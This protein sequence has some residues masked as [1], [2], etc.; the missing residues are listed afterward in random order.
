MQKACLVASHLKM[1]PA[2]NEFG[3]FSC[4]S[5]CSSPERP[6]IAE[7]G[8]SGKLRLSVSVQTL[9]AGNGLDGGRVRE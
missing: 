4:C 7:L 1:L 6:S 5:H 9:H 2:I 8:C 3:C